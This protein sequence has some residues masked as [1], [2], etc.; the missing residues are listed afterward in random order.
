MLGA[1]RTTAEPPERFECFW[2]MLERRRRVRRAL[3]PLMA[4]GG[5]GVFLLV[6]M[7]QAPASND[8]PRMVEEAYVGEPWGFVIAATHTEAWTD[9]HPKNGQPPSELQS[10]FSSARLQRALAPSAE[11]IRRCYVEAIPREEGVGPP[12]AQRRPGGH[13]SRSRWSSSDGGERRSVDA[14]RS[15]LVHRTRAG[16]REAPVSAVHLDGVPDAGGGATVRRHVVQFS[17]AV[18]ALLR[19]DSHPRGEAAKEVH[20]RGFDPRCARS[21]WRWR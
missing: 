19:Q 14:C 21:G 4:V 8:E 11:G 16:I 3:L 6:A 17:A 10:P 20:V 5:L 12:R 9:L 2:Q 1:Y 18:P 7:L 13:H 15:Q